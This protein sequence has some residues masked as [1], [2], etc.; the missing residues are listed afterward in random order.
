MVV[1]VCV[2]CVCVCVCVR[3]CA[4][5]CAC[6]PCLLR[7]CQPSSWC[8][9]VVVVCFLLLD[10]LLLLCSL[11]ALFSDQTQMYGNAFT[12]CYLLRS[13]YPSLCLLPSSKDHSPL[14]LPSL[15]SSHGCSHSSIDVA[16]LLLKSRCVCLALVCPDPVV[17]SRSFEHGL[18]VFSL[19]WV[20]LCMP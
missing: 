19:R 12:N 18:N 7:A 4:Y 2:V 8:C 13:Y 15:P 6:V 9:V 1:S 10:K 16:V 3:V 14:H 17:I 5:A 20:K 11:R